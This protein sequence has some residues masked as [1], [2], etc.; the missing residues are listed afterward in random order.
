M[1]KNDPMQR[2]RGWPM[3]KKMLIIMKLTTVLFFIALFQVSASKTYSQVTKLSL[4]FENE[5]LENVFSKIEAN[6]EFSI[7]YK[8]ELIKN[9]KEV[10]G[11]FK[12][13]L[14]FDI[15]DQVLKSENLSYTIKDKLIMIVSKDYVAGEGMSQQNER[16]VNGKVTDQSGAPIPGASVVIKGTTNGVVTD[17]DG[18]FILPNI[19]ENGTLVFSFVGMKGQE[20]PVGSKQTINV[21]M[22]EETIALDEVISIGYGTKRKADLTGSVVRADINLFKDQ[23]NTSIAQSL[24]GTVPGLNVGAVTSAGEDP[25]VSIRGVNSFSGSTAPL[26][27]LDGV[28]FHGALIDINQNDIESVDILK[29]ASAKAIY[30][31]QAANGIMIITS[32]KGDKNKK[33]V[34][35]FST[36][37]AIQTPSNRLHP[38]NKAEYLNK[39]GQYNYEKAYLAPDYTQ[40]DPSFDVSNYF[41]WPTTKDGFLNGTNTNWLDLATRN[42]SITNTNLSMAGSSNRTN[43]FLSSEYIKQDGYVR[44]DQYSKYTIRANFENHVTDWLT[45][46]MQT[47]VSSGDYSGVPANLETA[48]LLHPMV[49]PY[50]ADGSL[51]KFVLGGIINPLKNLE[52]DDFD[53]RL[54]IF[55]NFSANFTIPYV[56]GLS[57]K[58]NYAANY[59]T[60]RNYQAN[61]WANGDKGSAYKYNGES[62][63]QTLDNIVTYKRRFYEKHDLDATL[64]Y[65]YEKRDGEGTNGSGG[66]FLNQA[67]GY[68]GLQNGDANSRG[69]SSSGWK[70]YSLYQMARLNYKYNDRYLVTLSVR[71]DGFSGFGSNKKFG[72]FP[73]AALAWVATKEKFIAEALPWADNL[74][75]RGSYGTSGNR[76]AGRYST[77]AKVSSSYVYVFGDNGTPAYGQTISSLANNDLGW[78]TTTGLNA[79]IDFG[80]L[81]NRISGSIEYYNNKTK[82]VL[83]D[84]LL[85]LMTGFNSVTT[86]IGKIANNGIEVSITSVNIKKANFT[87]ETTVNFSKNNNKIV[88]ILGPKN[89]VE[90]DLIANGLFIGKPLGAIYN[91]NVIGKYQISD[92]RPA[93]FRPGHYKE[94]DLNGDGKIDPT[95]DRK[96]LG[97]SIPAY[98]FSIINTF[99]YKNWSLSVFVN[100]IQGGK[101]NYL[102]D[103]NPRHYSGWYSSADFSNVNTPRELDFWSPTNPNAKF[104]VPK[105]DD[106]IS[107]AIY[108]SRSFVRLQDINLTYKIP[109]KRLNIGVDA[110]GIFFSGKNL[111]TWTNWIGTDPETGASFSLGA[112]PVMTSYSLGFNLTF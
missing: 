86:N 59:R 18:N 43:Y 93:G 42:G 64:L 40:T 58:I 108:K 72:V 69:I 21:A 88:S 106:P 96:I 27:I 70:E 97:S 95:N 33:P 83:F 102:G 10:S 104:A 13:A 81:K 25:S 101:N 12:D 63:D 14:I 55:G 110:L 32:K 26:I 47:F 11:E 84:V 90:S 20:I 52:I 44:N 105:Y 112:F 62:Q 111:Y 17:N 99:S 85:P 35:N 7:F 30:G 29:D 24:Q 49:A 57:Y 31:S 15:L 51:K 61:K 23:P 37:H 8:N 94:E 79:A 76:T 28:I 2:H 87:W 56:K 92:T 107:P 100:S 38:L 74:K 22:V 67:L 50:N 80:V 109:C 16:K 54:N 103:I 4:K 65:G 36:Y 3:L 9:S 34:F 1:K 91:Y 66:L 82:D 45:L 78:E 89:G 46:G 77:L 60:Q 53:K 71:R 39:I 75:V 98:R 48:Y 6:S 68:N 73:S 19:P 5:T 41:M